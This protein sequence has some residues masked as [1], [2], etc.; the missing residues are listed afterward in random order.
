MGVGAYGSTDFTKL[1]WKDIYSGSNCNCN[2]D[3]KSA[4]IVGLASVG[5]IFGVMALSGA[6]KSGKGGNTT[7]TSTQTTVDPNANLNKQIED[8]EK[9]VAEAKTAETTAQTNWDNLVAAWNKQNEEVAKQIETEKANVEK[10]NAAVAE[11]QKYQADLNLKNERITSTK[12]KINTLTVQ[13][14]GLTAVIQTLEQTLNTTTDATAKSNIQSKLTEAK[15]KKADKEQEIKNQQAILE[16]AKKDKAAL[17]ANI[18]K[19]NDEII[20]VDTYKNAQ[21]E[22]TKLEAQRNSSIE[23]TK[24]G[25]K[26]KEALT[27]ATENVTAQEEKL[28]NLKK[29]KDMTANADALDGSGVSRLLSKKSSQGNQ[30]HNYMALKDKFEADP[31]SLTKEELETLQNAGEFGNNL[32]QNNIGTAKQF[33]EQLTA[34]HSNNS[35]KIDEALKFYN[36]VENG[37]ATEADLNNSNY[38][39]TQKSYVGDKLATVFNGKGDNDEYTIQNDK[40]VALDRTKKG[41]AVNRAH[42]KTRTQRQSN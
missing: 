23:D 13:R 27:K 9:V 35:A 4:A 22:L 25:Q 16:Q 33:G 14:D 15:Q 10:Y 18:K 37:Q 6:F 7:S 34:W 2:N 5:S 17:E 1:G 20:N 19:N 21:S 28:E 32:A 31:T 29:Q 3:A 8:Q 30:I 39:K 36:R 26:A 24:E 11:N 42:F 41:T 12:S 40:V 38:F